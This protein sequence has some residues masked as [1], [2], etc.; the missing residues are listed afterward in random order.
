MLNPTAIANPEK[1]GPEDIK[2]LFIRRF[3]KDVKDQISK[4][5]PERIVHKEV[6]TASGAEE[7]AYDI[8]TSMHFSKPE[9]VRNGSM[10]FKTTLE[11]SLFSSPAAC[12]E[13]L[14]NRIS[15]LSK[16]DDDASAKDVEQL[17]ELD[18]ALALIDKNAMS[19]YQ[20]LLKLLLPKTGTMKWSP[21]DSKDRVVIFTERIETMRFLAENLKQDLGLA[22]NQVATLYG[23]MSDIDIQ[24]TVEQFG[25]ESSK[26]RLLVCSDV[27]SEG[28][29]LHYFSHRMIHFDIPWS[30]MVFQQR[31]G[32]IDRYGQQIQPEIYY[33]C[34]NSSNEKIKGDNRILELLIEKDKEVQESI[35]D[36]SEFT[37]CYS[38]EDEIAKVGTAMEKGSSPQTFEEQL[39]AADDPLALLLGET[40]VPTGSTAMEETKVLP[41]IFASDFQYTQEALNYIQQQTNG[42]IQ[43]DIQENEKTISVTPTEEMRYRL[44]FLPAEVL[45]ESGQIHL[46]ADHAKIEKEITRCRES[47]NSWPEIQLLWEQH[48]MLEYLNDKVL[49]SFARQQAPVIEMGEDLPSDECV[50]LVYAVIPNRK[51]QPV[52]Y[53][54]YGVHYKDGNFVSIQPIQYWIDKLALTKNN[55]PNP[56]HPVDQEYFQIMISDVVEKTREAILDERQDWEN[57]YN[58]KLNEHLEALEKLR[59]EHI[60]QLEFDF[61]E[62]I[63]GERTRDEKA[64]KER[65]I[66]KMFD[67]YLTWIEDTMTTEKKPYIRIAAVLK[68]GY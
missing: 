54:W 20:H 48:P 13:T 22:E 17:R 26:I 65:A 59:G 45:P 58:P 3:K 44:K 28:I 33:L 36:P 7:N 43:F 40:E 14:R 53:S 34:V 61:S 67:D 15:T 5:F 63:M 37:G 19:K 51:S 57:K 29:N 6:I 64:Q 68:G 35:G 12:R 55:R 56:Q 18:D 32:R 10:L 30:L 60:Q 50:F 41:T 21:R 27:A 52:L 25:N 24:E 39:A 8:L 2:G 9:I 62:R 66:E 31:N 16:K 4:A 47:E 46:S 49:A 38:V 1:Y 42:N 11:K 23:G